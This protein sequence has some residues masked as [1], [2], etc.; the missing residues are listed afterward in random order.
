MHYP[1]SL[2][3]LTS[4]LLLSASLIPTTA[5]AEPA[6]PLRA[7]LR[8][9][10]GIVEVYIDGE[11]Q[12]RMWGRL[13]LPAQNAPEKLGQYQEA[14]IEVYLTNLD[15]EWNIGWNGDD[16]F[17][18]RPYELHLDRILAVK[19]D[20]KLILYVGYSGAAPY[21]WCRANEDQLVL[22]ANGDR[23]RMGSF[24]SEKWLADSTHAMRTFVSHFMN[25]RFAGNIV[26]IN[27]IMYSNEWHT[28]SSRMHPPLD[29]YS[30]PM[31]EHFRK[32]V[33]ARYDNDL[34]RLRA[35]W[36]L[37]DVTFETVEIPPQERRLRSDRE[38]LA[39]GEIDYWV[40]DYE[41]CLKEAREIFI[42]E[43]CRAVK[44]ASNGAWLTTLGRR[45]ESID[46]LK[47][48]WVDVFHGP[49]RY[50]NRKLMNVFS[51]GLH[52]YPLNGKLGMYQID[53]GTH[54]MPLTGGDPLGVLALWPGPFRLTDNEWESLEILERDVSR[55]IADNR[56]VY[57]NEGGPGWMFPVVNHGTVTYGRFWFDTPAIKELIGQTRK[58]VDYQAAISTPAPARVAVVGAHFQAPL[59]GI[60]NKAIDALF[61]TPATLYQLQRSGVIFHDFILEDFGVI[62]QSY[63][64]YIFTNAFYVPSELRE[65]IHAKLKADGATAIW[66]YGA[67][68]IDENGASL[69]NI[70]A[71]TGYQLQVKHE[72]GLV[73]VAHPDSNSPLMAGVDS[74]GSRTVAVSNN[75]DQ[76]LEF[77]VPE[78]ESK[79]LPTT[80]F[81]DDPEAETLA[82]YEGNGLPA[83][84]VKQADGFRSIWIGAPE[85]PWQMYQNL[86]E[87][88]GVHIYSR[89]GD[90]LMVNDHF[91]ALYCITKGEK[92]LSLPQP[93]NV[94][95][96]LTGELIAEKTSEIRFTAKAGETR[97]F[98]LLP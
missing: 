1:R 73:Q 66:L 61:N 26:G 77:Y 42:I 20:I 5:H 25:S 87:D 68:F 16:T 44:E 49:Y 88:S 24:A 64:V 12:S 82:V 98:H 96:A 31:R 79:K 60:S 13:A 58:M 93:R 92:T 94:F 46:M 17:D 3:A 52:T 69:E 36:N 9:E 37:A 72:T 41:I 27:P 11:K 89:T 97:S 39:F 38:P 85:V 2:L 95:D 63:D 18:F 30:Q 48:E 80:F 32:W 59:L 45:P 22:L 62:D 19:P 8:K 14:G 50:R 86:I 23:L 71:L 15:M 78:F 90:Y 74:F 57:W 4:G 6:V 65:Q 10:G 28:P 7:E 91:I 43:T 40:A 55:A 56:Y 75:S 84:A 81:A 54:V 83:V 51:Y 21:K 76:S 53:T 29:D 47:S 34:E 70:R 33:R 35:R 67:G